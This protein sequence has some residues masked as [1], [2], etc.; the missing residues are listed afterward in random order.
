MYHN[1]FLNPPNFLD[2][3]RPKLDIR[4]SNISPKKSSVVIYKENFFDLLFFLNIYKD[5][6]Y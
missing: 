5:K 3:A 1:V 4:F 2:W 6:K